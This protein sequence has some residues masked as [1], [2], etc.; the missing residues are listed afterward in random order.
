MRKYPGFSGSQSH[1]GLRDPVTPRNAEEEEKDVPR[2]KLRPALAWAPRRRGFKGGR[3][4]VAV[5]T[6]WAGN[7][8]GRRE[9]GSS[10]LPKMG[11]Q[12]APVRAV[13][14]DPLPPPSPTPL[15][16]GESI[17]GASHPLAQPK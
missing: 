15:P 11:G 8:R 4:L 5:D 12:A 6:L 14:K 3:N 16:R 7:Q 13:R 17:Q 1:P 10:Y 2:P 9:R